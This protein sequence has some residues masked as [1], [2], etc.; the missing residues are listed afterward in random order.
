[1]TKQEI[2][3]KVRELNLP[4]GL[5][6]VFGSAP[7][8]IRGIRD[9]NDIDLLV[10]EEVFNSLRSAGWKQIEKGPSDKPLVKGDYEAHQNWNFSSYKP[11]LKHLLQSAELEEG[12]PFAS[13]DEVRKWK[14]ASGRPKDLIDIELIDTYRAGQK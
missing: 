5:Y 14:F 1:M 11:T 6:I 13:L 12:I 4:Q 10:S 3:N 9:A 7:L 8:A 2:I